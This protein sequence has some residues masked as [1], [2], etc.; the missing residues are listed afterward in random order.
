M[1]GI[2]RQPSERLV[3]K[4]RLNKNYKEKLEDG[5]QASI[6]GVFVSKDRWADYQHSQVEI[7]KAYIK[8][9]ENPKGIIDEYIY[10]PLKEISP[11]E[12]K[13]FKYVH[14]K[15]TYSRDVLATFKRK[16]I[17]DICREYLIE[18]K[19]RITPFLIGKILEAQTEYKKSMKGSEDF[20]DDTNKI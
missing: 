17:E 6:N 13:D 8:S 9:F 10:D 2:T 5:S 20:F 18:T 4:Y 3:Y 11:S 12:P 19:E 15:K 16:E 14:R 1:N 7:L